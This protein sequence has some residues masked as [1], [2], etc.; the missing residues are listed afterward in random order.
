MQE[1]Q[2]TRVT[3]GDPSRHGWGRSSEEGNVNPFQCSCLGKPMDRGVWW[4]TVHGV[5]KESDTTQGLSH[6]SSHGTKEHKTGVTSI[7]HSAEPRVPRVLSCNLSQTASETWFIALF[8]KQCLPLGASFIFSTPFQ[9][10]AT[11]LA[12]TVAGG[13]LLERGALEPLR[14]CFHPHSNHLGPG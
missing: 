12:A 6:H 9:P 13:S 2:K 11:C 3:E 1:T 8:C 14:Q 4:A 10:Q 5:A 7:A